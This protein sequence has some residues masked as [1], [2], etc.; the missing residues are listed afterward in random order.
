VVSSG[1]PPPHMMSF[2]F[3]NTAKGESLE[4]SKDNSR[5]F[6]VNVCARSLVTISS[7]SVSGVSVTRGYFSASP[8]AGYVAE[9]GNHFF[10]HSSTMVII[11]SEEGQEG[12]T[13]RKKMRDRQTDR[14]TDRESGRD[15]L[16]S[17]LS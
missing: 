9:T 1:M 8:L 2:S 15:S 11:S 3:A 7:Q 13:E 4:E 10:S 6:S 5:A 12:E 14:Q 16:R 17:M